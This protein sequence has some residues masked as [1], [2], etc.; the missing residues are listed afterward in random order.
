MEIDPLR[1]SR[2]RAVLG[3]VILVAGLAASAPA[4]E[5]DVFLDDFE[6][7]NA[8]MWSSSAG[9]VP[10]GGFG[11]ISGTCGVLSPSNLESASP[12]LFVSAFDF[13]SDAYDEGDY[14]LLTPGG[15]KIIDDAGSSG[16]SVLVDV[17]SFEWL[18]R[19]EFAA[20]LKTATEIDYVEPAGK[21]ADL[22]VLIDGV[23]IGITAT[24]A[25]AYPPEDP[26]TVEQATAL[27]EDKLAEV[28]E[29]TANV[30]PV[31]Q[32]QKQILTV[33]AYGAGHAASLETAWGLLAPGLQADT[34]VVVIVTNGDDGFLY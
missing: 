12:F 20:L 15:Q 22:I 29:S 11:E 2:H 27:L 23:H 28:L 7:G 18:A 25:Y 34:I 4:T 31:D 1:H 14:G 9:A 16:S 10:L 3:T 13:G 6:T 21:K 24:R 26:Y 30:S 8:S 33:I 5:T 17:F 19:C 32:W